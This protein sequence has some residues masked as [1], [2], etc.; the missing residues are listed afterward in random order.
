MKRIIGIA[1]MIPGLCLAAAGLGPSPPETGPPPADLGALLEEAL[2]ASPAVRAAAAR[3]E[4]ARRVPS[5]AGTAPDP[6]VGLAYTNDGLST[7]TYG[8]S[9][10]SNLTLSWRQEVP[11]PGKLRRSAEAATAEA[12]IAARQED[13][14]R[15]EVAS[16]VKGMFAELYR[17]D[18]TA[19]ILAETKLVL[20]SLAE[21]ARRRYEVGQGIQESVLKAQTEI[22]RLEAELARVH[23]DRRAVK[24]RLDAVLGR[25]DDLPIGPVERLPEA[26]L[27]ADTGSLTEAAVTASPAVLG[28][29]ADV[30]RGEARLQFTRLDLK[31]DFIWSASYVD[32]G[33]IDPMVMGM[34]GVRLPIHRSRKQAQAAQQAASEL[35]AAR[36]A[37]ADRRLQVSASVRELVARVER[38]DRLVRL[39]GQGVIPQATSTLE[40]AQASYGVGRIGFLDVLNDLTAVLDARIDLATQESDRFQALASLEPLV[41]REVIVVEG[42]SA[43][44]GARQEGGSDVLDQ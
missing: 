32:R 5:Q 25:A 20:E 22:L 36:H 29:E 42:R 34:F 40:S 24:V 27:S 12:D 33:A 7:I 31:P 13:R 2:S 8:D 35:E 3:L 44:A 14:V 18:R 4:A 30:R 16:Q 11:Y 38:A 41:G 26:A 21:S 10:M 28:L 23:Q 9:I 6:E 39:Y 1:L 17:L 43:E 19:A 37:L 15:L